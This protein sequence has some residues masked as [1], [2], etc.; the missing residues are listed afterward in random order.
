M[1]ALAGSN[2]PRC[3]AAVSSWAGL[4]ASS[5]AGSGAATRAGLAVAGTCALR[6]RRAATQRSVHEMES[7]QYQRM[8]AHAWP[9]SGTS[10]PSGR[11]MPHNEHCATS[12]GRSWSRCAA[13][14]GSADARR[15]LPGSCSDPVP[16]DLVKTDEACEAMSPPRGTLVTRRP[17]LLAKPGRPARESAGKLAHT[18][19]ARGWAK[20]AHTKPAYLRYP[21]R[22]ARLKAKSQNHPILTSS[23]VASR[24]PPSPGVTAA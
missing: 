4:A 1:A 11:A 6:C 22:F 21:P 14:G 12:S 23:P 13:V 15:G 9:P 17:D 8:S 2:T 18:K 24:V 5:G 7:L 3:F 20:L 19:P 10:K 16:R